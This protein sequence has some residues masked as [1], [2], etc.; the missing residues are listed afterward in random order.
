MAHIVTA[1]LGADAVG[2]H[3]LGAD[4]VATLGQEKIC[5]A[6]LGCTQLLQHTSGLNK[7]DMKDLEAID[8]PG[9]RAERRAELEAA[10]GVKGPPPAAPGAPFG[11]DALL[12]AGFGPEPSDPDAKALWK[13]TSYFLPYR[14]GDRKEYGVRDG[15]QFAKGFSALLTAENGPLFMKALRWSFPIVIDLLTRA[16]QVPL[17]IGRAHV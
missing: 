2:A 14:E 1:L 13:R 12:R 11:V 3:A 15:Q 8:D 16:M 6:D 5:V 10:K 9:D 17:E 7:K 4:H